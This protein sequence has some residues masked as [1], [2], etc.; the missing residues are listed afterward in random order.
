MGW[1]VK[2]SWRY[3]IEN[4]SSVRKIT[5]VFHNKFSVKTHYINLYYDDIEWNMVRIWR[6]G[7]RIGA[8]LR[9]SFERTSCGQHYW[10][11]AA[12]ATTSRSA[13]LI[14]LMAHFPSLFPVSDW[15]WGGS[16]NQVLPTRHGILLGA[17][18]FED[19]SMDWLR[20]SQMILLSE[21]LPTQFS[22][23]LFTD[24]RSS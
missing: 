4:Y 2:L 17:N 10:L 22:P 14:M 19:I 13:M 16:Q 9:S 3:T 12:A 6:R 1:L 15:A 7:C 20:L 5:K 11:T 21:L 18:S 8:L 24:V 23:W